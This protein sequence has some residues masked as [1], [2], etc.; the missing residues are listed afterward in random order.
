MM[1]FLNRAEMSALAGDRERLAG[2]AE[3][4]AAS[5]DDSTTQRFAAQCAAEL[6]EHADQ[7]RRGINPYEADHEI[8]QPGP[9]GGAH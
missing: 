3:A 5:A 4:A 8:W 9:Q 7:L 6:R 1:V 2:E